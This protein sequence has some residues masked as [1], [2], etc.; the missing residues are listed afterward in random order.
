M[1]IAITGNMGSGKSTVLKILE[2]LGFPVFDADGLAKNQYERDDVKNAMLA[3]FGTQCMQNN[4]IDKQF[5]ASRI[6][7]NSSEKE[8]V[9]AILYPLV[10]A[11]IEQLSLKYQDGICFTE[12]PLLYESHAETY[13]DLVLLIVSEQSIANQRLIKMRHYTQAK[14]DAR[15]K[16][17][18][19]LDQK[20]RLADDIITNNHDEPQLLKQV[21]AYSDKIKREYGKK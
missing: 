19:S 12:V 20:M 21:I 9:E 7:M 11:E 6:F 16:H 18:W 15:L 2:G 14:I 1:H 13:F 8:K 17:Q 4:Q 5:I 10:F 3:L